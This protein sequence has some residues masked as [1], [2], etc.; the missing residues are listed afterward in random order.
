MRVNA[1][2]MSV[3]QYLDVLKA[4]HI[5]AAG[6]HAVRLKTPM[7]VDKIPGF[8][9]GVVSVQDA[10]AQLAAQLPNARGASERICSA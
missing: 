7:A 5:E 2:R 10:G 1:R 4:E 3:A 6:I 9:D 8:A